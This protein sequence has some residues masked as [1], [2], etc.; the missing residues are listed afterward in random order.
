MM[1]NLINSPL[2]QELSKLSPFE[3]KG[4]I[5]AMANERVKR[6]ANTMLNAGRG[7]PNWIAS[8]PRDAFFALGQFAM[9][10]CRR[11]FEM[12]EGITG[13][14]QQVGTRER[15]YARCRLPAQGL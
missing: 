1:D 2:D 5:I 8:V 14:P 9:T 11:D 15:E 3:L 13:V 4:R 6:N 12:P 10:E 7:N